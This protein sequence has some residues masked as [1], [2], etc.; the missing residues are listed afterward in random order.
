VQRSRCRDNR[1]LTNTS[2]PTPLKTPPGTGGDRRDELRSGGNGLLVD[3]ADCVQGADCKTQVCG[4]TEDASNVCRA[5]ACGQDEVCADDGS[6][7]ETAAA[8]ARS[9]RVTKRGIP[10]KGP[11]ALGEGPGNDCY[12]PPPMGSCGTE[13]Y[14]STTD[15]AGTLCFSATS[16]E[17]AALSDLACQEVRCVVEQ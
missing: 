10:V 14:R 13:G 16:N 1:A 11:R 7:C 17:V 5:V 12:W 4:V 15:A 9:R 8:R 3:G 6:A 2:A